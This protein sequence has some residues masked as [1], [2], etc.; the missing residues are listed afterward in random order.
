MLKQ[1]IT[2]LVTKFLTKR[3]TFALIV[4]RWFVE[5]PRGAIELLYHIAY[6]TE[7]KRT[8]VPFDTLAATKVA[9]ASLVNNVY[10]AV[11]LALK[12][13]LIICASKECREAEVR[14]FF[15]EAERIKQHSSVLKVRK[16]LFDHVRKQT[17]FTDERDIALVAHVLQDTYTH[18]E[19]ASKFITSVT[20][21]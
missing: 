18:V 5:S 12:K 17:L 14:T 19:A 9:E 13:K 11:L 20:G 1:F 6:R 4:D 15:A 3:E 21:E 16:E 10:M 7:T 2:W 8:I